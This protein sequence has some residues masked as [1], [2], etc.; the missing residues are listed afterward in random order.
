VAEVEERTLD[1]PSVF[2]GRTPAGMADLSLEM[3]GMA[4][5][6]ESRRYGS[7][8]RMFT[9]W[10]APNVETSGIFLG[11]VGASLGLGLAWG[12]L[13][14]FIGTLAGCLPVAAAASWGPATGTAQLPLARLSFGRSIALPGIVQW[15]SS[16]AWDALVGLFG[17]EA[18]SYALGIPFAAAVAIVLAAEG[19]IAA[20]GY[21]VVHM[22]E[23]AATVLVGAAFVAFSIKLLG[24]G[25]LTPAG[26][27]LH[28]MSLAGAFILMCTL[29]FSNGISWVSYASDYSRYL[30]K[31]ISSFK[32]GLLTWAGLVTSYLWMEGIGLAAGQLLTNQTAAGIYHLSGGGG[33]GSFVLAGV[34]LGA[35]CS[36]TMNDYTGSLALQAAGIRIWRPISA[37]VVM[38]AAYALVLWLHA[39]D[40]VSRFSDLLLF[41]SYWLSPFF[42]VIALDWHWRREEISSQVR[43]ILRWDRLPSGW[44]AAVALVVGFGASVP[45]MNASGVIEG[46][47]ARALD[48]GDLAYY[49]GMVVAAAVYWIARRPKRPKPTRVGTRQAVA[50]G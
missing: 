1:A 14:I 10:F 37:L 47:I 23:V 2:S 15:L 22:V 4:P 13:A 45:F 39:G 28:G 50:T 21:E 46:P 30:P 44:E 40:V 9:V 18:I 20:L 31:E 8:W 16:V 41:S 29:S 24:H 7:A 11:A 43:D 17:G 48:G 19:A 12:A 35:V 49:V 38:V 5:I 6:E 3:R 25:G 26:T 33:L 27:S 32:V 34:A 42:A 36:N